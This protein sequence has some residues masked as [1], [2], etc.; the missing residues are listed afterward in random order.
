[1]STVT[2]QLTGATAEK[3]KEAIDQKTAR[4]G[5]VGLGY[6]GL[7]TAAVFASRANAICASRT[8]GSRSRPSSRC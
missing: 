1:M 3:L 4:V 6:V 8:F 2:N 7:P 5:I